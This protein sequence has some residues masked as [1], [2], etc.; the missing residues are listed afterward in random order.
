[1]QLS[2]IIENKYDTEFMTRTMNFFLYHLHKYAFKEGKAEKW[3]ILN[4]LKGIGMTQ[5]P[6]SVI[7]S[8]NIQ[9]F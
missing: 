2:V 9:Q 4:D 6:V 7:N 8:I 3:I 5:L 1:M